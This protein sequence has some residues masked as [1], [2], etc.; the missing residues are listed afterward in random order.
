MTYPSL[1]D[2]VGEQRNIKCV[3]PS[4]GQQTVNHLVIHAQATDPDRVVDI[5]NA[6]DHHVER[7]SETP[8]DY[9]TVVAAAQQNLFGLYKMQSLDVFPVTRQNANLFGNFGFMCGKFIVYSF[10]NIEGNYLCLIGFVI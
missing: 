5:L 2:P 10:F 6:T 9:G 8:E 4:T 1:R 3:D 7:M